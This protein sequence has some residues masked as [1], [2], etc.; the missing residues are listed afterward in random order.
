MSDLYREKKVKILIEVEDFDEKEWNSLIHRISTSMKGENLNF[1]RSFGGKLKEN[2]RK[3][4]L[5]F[6]KQEVSKTESFSLPK[7]LGNFVEN[8][9]KNNL[10]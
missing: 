3:K 8:N 6:K 5:T 9:E 7:S 10:N 4:F 1:V 2:K